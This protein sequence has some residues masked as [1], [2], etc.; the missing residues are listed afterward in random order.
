M[1]L[2]SRSLWRSFFLKNTQRFSPVFIS[3]TLLMIVL[4]YFL[5]YFT[6][7]TQ[8]AYLHAMYV[9]VV[10]ISAVYGVKGGVIIGIIAGVLLG[11][12]MPHDT[13]N[14]IMQDSVN[15]IYRMIYFIGVGALVGFILD[16]VRSQ[17]DMIHDLY[18]H[19]TDTGL[20]NYQMYL[21]KYNEHDEDQADISL[22]FLINNYED[23]LVLVGR[24][25]YAELL[26]KIYETLIAVL[27]ESSIYQVDVCKLWIELSQKSFKNNYVKM[28]QKFEEETFI[29]NGVPLFVDLS[30]GV[31]IGKS[32]DFSRLEAFR[33]SEI[34]ALYAK[35]NMLKYSIYQSDFSYPHYKLERLGALPR[36][37]KNNELFLEYHPIVNL[38]TGQVSAFE[39][40]VRW[41]KDGEI[42]SPLDFIPLAEETKLIDAITEWI[43]KQVIKDYAL[44]TNE[45]DVMVNI[46]LS[47]RNLYNPSLIESIIENIKKENYK[48]KT[49]G[50]EMTESTVMLNLNLTRTLL[51]SL[52]DAGIPMAIDDFGTGYST[53]ACL[54]ELPIDRLKIDRNFV[55][56]MFQDKGT[57]QL[58]QMIVNYAHELDIEVIAEGIETKNFEDALVNMGCD[59]GQGF[60]YAKPMTV[61]DAK[62]F[63]A[64]YNGKTKKS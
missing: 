11:P 1:K 64:K 32:E 31:Y 29:I 24:S 38:K 36:A 48:D 54:S 6:G 44:L 40:L 61:E 3:F 28:L 23:I 63:M 19:S 46:N 15:W 21:S 33:A 55:A 39:A 9:P 5:V 25:H 22:T 12:L 51:T 20:P 37:I 57:E 41:R 17:Y 56:R 14:M 34:A 18:T 27:H 7:G 43:V 47:Q 49:I 60:Y 52:K 58:I 30:I 2:F 16:R 13:V 50:V 26:K 62:V 35:K 45:N 8:N 53:L 42:I 59:F 10:F 4:V